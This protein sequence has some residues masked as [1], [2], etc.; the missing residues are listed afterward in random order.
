LD[1]RAALGP[2][3]ESPFQQ[4]HRLRLGEFQT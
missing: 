2:H 3:V 4:G 1:K